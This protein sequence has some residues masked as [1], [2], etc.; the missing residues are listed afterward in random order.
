MK[1]LPSQTLKNTTKSL[2]LLSCLFTNLSLASDD[3]EPLTEEET[4][5]QKDIKEC[6]EI[7]ENTGVVET[8]DK[9][10]WRYCESKIMAK[11]SG[12]L[13]RYAK[14]V[15]AE[16]ATELNPFVITPHEPSYIMPI[17]YTNN[18]NHEPYRDFDDEVIDEV[19]NPTP[20]SDN[21]EAHE[22]KYQISFKVPLRSTSLFVQ[23]DALYFAMTIQAWWQLYSDEI[24]KPFRE[25]NYKPEIFYVSPLPWQ[26]ENGSFGYFISFEHQSNG[27]SQGLSRSWNRIHL[28]LIYDTDNY[29]IG[30]KPWYRIP[31]DEKEYDLAPN[32]D[33]NPDIEDY[34]GHYEI[35]G[36]YAFSEQHK[37]SG[38][39][40][41]NWSTGNGSI[42]LNYTFPLP[43]SA[44]LVGFA[45]FFSGYGESLIDY[46]HRQEKI[47]IGIALTDVF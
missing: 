22:A 26:T 18:F 8:N 27:Q 47:G 33:D 3:E 9:L 10:V 24:S 16:R 44:R 45:Q 30:I 46:N 37:L 7:L 2:L 15:L 20:F 5:F 32:G 21:L 12:K 11:R 19:H 40:R 1:S 14:R 23:G 17:T 31:E 38:T 39:F 34:L 13:G 43:F 6:V 41:Q 25:T 4:L 42:E 36:A 29:S 35:M 28:G